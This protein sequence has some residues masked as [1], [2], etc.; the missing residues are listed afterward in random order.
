MRLDTVRCGCGAIVQLPNLKSRLSRCADCLR[1][2]AER[3]RATTPKHV[4]QPAPIHSQ[5]TPVMRRLQAGSATEANDHLQAGGWCEWEST[6]TPGVVC[7]MK[8]THAGGY[9]YRRDKHRWALCGCFSAPLFCP[10]YLI[11]A[12]ND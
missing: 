8:W 11:E 7:Q 10:V 1:R 3:A 5:K 2:D 4:P 12:G 6:A 9:Q